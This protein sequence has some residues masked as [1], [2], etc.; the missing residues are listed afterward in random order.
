MFFLWF[1]KRTWRMESSTKSPIFFLSAAEH[2]GDALGA[3]LITALRQEFPTARFVG[4]GGDKMAAAG[5]R[6]LANPTRHSAM[7]LGAVKQIGYWTK[8]LEQVK[9]QFAIERP[10]VVIPIDSPTVNVRVARLARRAGI[11]VCYY[12]APQHWAWAAWRTNELRHVVDT[13]CCVLE[14]EENY[15]QQ[16]GLH[17]VYV[18]HPLFDRPIAGPDAESAQLDPPLPAGLVKLAILPGSRRAEVDANFPVM[19]EVVRAVK[20]RF[21][22][23]IFAAAAADEERAWQIRRLLRQTGTRAEVRTGATDAIISWADLVLTVSG[24]ATLQVAR[25]HKPM[26]VLY[27]LA[28][29]KWNLAGRF[30][31]QTHFMSLVNILANRE[32]VPEFMPFYGSPAK[33]IQTTLD[34][35]NSPQRLREMSGAL[36]ELTAPIEVFCR[37]MPASRRV[38]L[39][40]AKIMARK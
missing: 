33:L 35:L 19:L 3:A 1:G 32:L 25:W 23:S 2:S 30:L 16:K 37:Q 9:Q 34:L 15:F 29:W 31:V 21:A 18:G 28:R 39:E 5:C 36:E 8:L 24:T 38:A 11:G 7:L 6:L 40:V 22:N 10:A 12:V 4:I 17:A 26:I 13:L 20:G 14:F 27:A